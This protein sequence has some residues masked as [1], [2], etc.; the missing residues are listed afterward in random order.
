MYQAAESEAK[1]AYKEPLFVIDNYFLW[2]F[3]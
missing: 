3:D 2:R 1:V